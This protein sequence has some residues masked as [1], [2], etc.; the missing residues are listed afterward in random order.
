MSRSFLIT[1]LV[2]SLLVVTRQGLE[3]EDSDAG[4]PP[5]MP[6]RGENASPK[7][8]IP[9][10]VIPDKMAVPAPTVQDQLKKPGEPLTTQPSDHPAIPEPE[11]RAVTPGVPQRSR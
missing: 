9:V 2:V 11:K 3:A 10:P 4:A 7:E 6:H 8:V 1:A 5:P